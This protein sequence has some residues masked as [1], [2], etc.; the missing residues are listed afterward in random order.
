MDFEEV[1]IYALKAEFLSV[2]IEI[3]IR[4]NETAFFTN[5]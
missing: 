5:P 3:Y 2:H 4:K 1:A